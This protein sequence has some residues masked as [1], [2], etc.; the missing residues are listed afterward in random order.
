MVSDTVREFVTREVLP[1]IESHF[2]EGTFPRHLVPAMAEMGLFGANLEGYGCAALGNVAYGLI[3]QELERG[4]S[5]LRSLV[6]VQ[7]GLV[8]YPILSFGS[9][10]QKSRWIPALR[11]GEALGCFGLTEPDHGSDPGG[12]KTRAV[13][14]DQLVAAIMATSHAINIVAVRSSAKK[15]PAAK[16]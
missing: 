12:M 13:N 4:D 1:V 10:E 9:E 2:R 16:R 7:A 15:R 5:G 11:K 6:S 3:N 8:M 14:S